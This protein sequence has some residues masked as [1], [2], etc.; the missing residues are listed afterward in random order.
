MSE[1]TQAFQNRADAIQSMAKQTGG[2]V[3]IAGFAGTGFREDVGRFFKKGISKFKPIAFNALKSALTGF[4]KGVTDP[5]NTD[6]GSRAISGLSAA[7]KAAIGSIA[8]DIKKEVGMGISTMD[9]GQTAKPRRPK[10]GKK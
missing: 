8:T 10:I 2:D 6:L 1:F 4:A 3:G 5:V 7:G 9:K